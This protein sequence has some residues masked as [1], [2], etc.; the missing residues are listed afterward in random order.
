MF[1]LQVISG[2]FKGQAIHIQQGRPLTIGRSPSCHVRFEDAAISAIHAEVTWNNDGFAVSDV[3]SANGTW[4]NGKRIQGRSGLRLGDHVKVGGVIFQLR[5]IEG[6]REVELIEPGTQP[7]M[8]AFDAGK[9]EVVQRG[10][11]PVAKTAVAPPQRPANPTEEMPLLGIRP[12]RTQMA[13]GIAAAEVDDQVLSATAELKQR[14]ES[15]AQGAKVVVR[16]EGRLDPFWALPVTIGRE[17]SSGIVLDDPAA[18]QRHAVLDLRDGRY[19]IRDVG[20]SNGVFVNGKRVVEE[21]LADGDVIGIGAHAM[22]VVLGASCLGLNV[23]AP[24]IGEEALG[25]APTVTRVAAVKQPLG[26]AVAPAATKKRKK[27][28]SELVW[29]ATSDLDRGVFRGRSALL[30]LLLGVLVTG[31]MLAMGDSEVL[32]GSKLADHHEGQAFVA[33]AERAGRDRCTACHI[34]AGQVSILKCLDC[35]PESRPSRAH[36]RADVDC[37]GCHLEHKGAGFQ[38]ATHASLACAESCHPNP[39]EALARTRPQLVAGFRL[40][41]EADVD[42]HVFHE[43]RKVACLACHAPSRGSPERGVRGACGQCHAPDNP[44]A[45]DCQLCHRGH[46]DRPATARAPLVPPREPPRFSAQ[47]VVWTLALLVLSFLLA[48]MIPRTR[49]VSLEEPEEAG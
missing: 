5:E 2:P 18:S 33:E 9:T 15:G 11:I 4:V 10:V 49:K 22:L 48:A 35:H 44:A 21:R 45:E 6:A 1:V 14:V 47:G 38:S 28:A 31:W 7:G 46:P 25:R 8:L 13:R 27:K 23:Q 41:A 32:S 24:R 39:H 42:F 16:R 19:L 29:Y 40:D 26:T 43:E 34:G 12:L 30:A 20:S 3:S 17:Q 36:A 37:L